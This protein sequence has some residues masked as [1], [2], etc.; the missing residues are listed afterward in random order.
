[1]P[2]S[3]LDLREVL[4]DVVAEMRN[5]AEFRGI[6][7]K[8]N[9]SKEMI[10]GN[11]AALHRAFLVLLDNALKYS[12]EGGEVI[13]TLSD[14]SIEIRDFGGGIS[15][16]DLPHIFK[17]FYQADRARSHGGYG[18]GL[19]LAETIVR[20]HGGSID[21]SSVLGEGSSFRVV[22]NG[23]KSALNRRLEA[24]ARP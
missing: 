13:V 22:L 24:L 10:S 20:A 5:L 18:L 9:L 14:T 15:A 8:Q 11:R 1:M 6:R 7:I 12:A 2:L 3:P 17:R 23:P 4:E 16:E 21:V 19:S